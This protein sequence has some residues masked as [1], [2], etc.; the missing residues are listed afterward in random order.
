MRKLN[1]KGFT[2]IELIVV[3]AILAILT[4]VLYPTY[5][6]YIEKSRE[7]V[8]LANRSSLMREANLEYTA[9]SIDSL[10]EGFDAL[11]LHYG[12]SE[13]CPSGG[14]YSWDSESET[15]VKISCSIHSS[16]AG[17]ESPGGGGSGGGTGSGG[18]TEY[19]PG[20]TVETQKNLWPEDSDYPETWSNYSLSAGTIFKYTDDEYYVVTKDVTMTKSQAASGPGGEVYGWFATHKITGRILENTGNGQITDLKRGDIY[21]YDNEYYVF[22]DGGSFAYPPNHPNVSSIS[23]YKLP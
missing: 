4:T 19:Y 15:A 22:I 11:Y 18:T 23:W 8:C 6:K 16:L 12:G 10:K 9:G 13:I 14:D 17:V 3:V 2:L 5:T 1:S 21:K 20:T 7:S